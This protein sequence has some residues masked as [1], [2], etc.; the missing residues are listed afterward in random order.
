MKNKKNPMTELKPEERIDTFKEVALGYTN[1][2]AIAEANRCLQCKNQPCVSGCPVSISIPEFIKAI[3]EDDFRSGMQIL[4]DSNNLPAVCG[5]VCPQEKQCEEKCILGKIPGSEPVAIGRLERFLADSNITTDIPMIRNEKIG[6]VAVIGSGP[7]SL[8]AAADLARIGCSVKV[9]E[10]F[11]SPGGVLLYGIPE[12]RLP[13]NI[14]RKEVEYIKSL[15]VEIICN[16][17]IGRTIPFEELRESFDAIFIGIGAG[18]P[19]FMGI[20][21]SNYNNIYSSSEFLTRVNLMRAN[22]FPKY[23]TPVKI[24]DRVAVIG[25]GNVAMDSARTA[26]RLGAKE[27]FVIYR[28][29]EAEMPARVEEYHHALEEGIIFNWLTLPTEYTGDINNEVTGIKC[30][31]MEL[32]EP[33]ESG[34]RKPVPLKDSEYLLK[35]EMVIEAIGQKANSVLE[36]GFPGLELNRWGYISADPD[37]GETNLPGVFAGG[38]IVT[39]SATVI[40]AMGAGKKAAKKIAMYIE[41]LKNQRIK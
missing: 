9:Y 27:V 5:R 20:A 19:R 1:N 23:D 11:H 40:Q 15:G 13:K 12:F 17:A 6:K 16:E 32:G 22:D 31:Q 18:A 30:V 25:G 33:D 41:E 36:T 29:S 39:G 2:E 7:A 24:K 3:R 10:A 34:R 35:V 37:T 38:D 14:V 8:T 21:G 28:R 26:K 4:R